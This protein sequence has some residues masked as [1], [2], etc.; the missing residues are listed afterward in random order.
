MKHGRKR[1]LGVAAFVGL[2]TLVLGLK[3]ATGAKAGEPCSRASDCARLLKP[4]CVFASAGNYCSRQCRDSSDCAAGWSCASAAAD[5]S[6]LAFS[7]P[8][9]VRP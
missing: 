8:V 7:A 3:T 6:R 4:A 5:M 9:C 1:A 2:L